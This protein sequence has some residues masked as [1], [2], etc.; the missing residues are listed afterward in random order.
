MNENQYATSYTN[1]N[2]H[3]IS[4]IMKI[5]FKE[6]KISLQV[7]QQVPWTK[8]ASWGEKLM[9]EFYEEKNQHVTDFTNKQRH[10]NRSTSKN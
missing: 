4:S 9:D 5:S 7:L 8:S 3:S 1:K 2:Q 6:R 10:A